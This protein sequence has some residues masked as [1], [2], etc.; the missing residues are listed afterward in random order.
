MVRF[1]HNFSNAHFLFGRYTIDD[2]SSLVPSFGTP[3]GTYV[4]GFPVRKHV[5]DQY[6]TLQDREDVGRELFK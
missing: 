2:G 1:D 3:P 6:F 4:A 5:R